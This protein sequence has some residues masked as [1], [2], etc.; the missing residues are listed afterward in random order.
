MAAGADKVETK[1]AKDGPRIPKLPPAG[2]FEVQMDKPKSK[3]FSDLLG[4]DFA[5]ETD[6]RGKGRF[7]DLIPRDVEVQQQTAKGG[8][9]VGKVPEASES[10]R[11]DA[12]A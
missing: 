11:D 10:S 3:A 5:V 6:K 4:G 2:E 8:R 7:D 9:P 12:V 1:T